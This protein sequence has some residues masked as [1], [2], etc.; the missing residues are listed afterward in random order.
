MWIY[1]KVIMWIYAKL[2]HLGYNRGQD[3]SNVQN[4]SYVF[5]SYENMNCGHQFASVT[6]MVYDA[7]M[8]TCNLMHADEEA[9]TT[10][11]GLI[12]TIRNV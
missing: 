10:S 8:Q 2:R 1:A 9:A 7:Y 3:G 6:E 12:E 5:S 11:K 4:F